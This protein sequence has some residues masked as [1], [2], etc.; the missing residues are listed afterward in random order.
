MET[1]SVPVSVAILQ[2]EDQE[3][4]FDW[5]EELRLHL[6]SFTILSSWTSHSLIS[7]VLVQKLPLF[8]TGGLLKKNIVVSHCSFVQKLRGEVCLALRSFYLLSIIILLMKPS[9]SLFC[10]VLLQQLPLLTVCGILPKQSLSG[11]PNVRCQCFPARGGEISPLISCSHFTFG[12]THPS[13]LLALSFAGTTA[14][15][16]QGPSTC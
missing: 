13:S 4:S 7:L 12:L 6:S 10:I 8:T 16:H 14:C 9:H 15:D 5:P 3:V 11:H 2:K 1:V